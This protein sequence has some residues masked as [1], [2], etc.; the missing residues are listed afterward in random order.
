LFG[1]ISLSA[2]DLMLRRAAIAVL[3]S[4]AKADAARRTARCGTLATDFEGVPAERE[5]MVEC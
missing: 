3:E 1:S 4:V 2:A 5:T